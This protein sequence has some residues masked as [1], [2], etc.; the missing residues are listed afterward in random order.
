[1]RIGLSLK[2]VWIQHIKT[3]S[4][5]SRYIIEAYYRDRNSVGIYL[6]AG[7]PAGGLVEFADPAEIMCHFSRNCKR[8]M[9]LRQLPAKIFPQ[10]HF[11]IA[12]AISHVVSGRI[13]KIAGYVNK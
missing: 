6:I 11:T 5:K 2:F 3:T 1:M 13:N 10:A 7:L 12:I 4:N 8:N 9:R